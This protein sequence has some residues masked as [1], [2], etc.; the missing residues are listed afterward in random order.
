MRR[1]E[2]I[3]VVARDGELVGRLEHV[4]AD[5]DTGR[6]NGLVIDQG[7]NIVIV[8]LSAIRRATGRI[9][10]LTGMARDYVNLPLFNRSDYRLLDRELERQETREWMEQ[11]GIEDFEIGGES[12]S[13]E[14]FDEKTPDAIEQHTGAENPYRR[15]VQNGHHPRPVEDDATDQ[16]DTTSE[17]AQ[18]KISERTR[19]DMH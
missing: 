2:T 12:E 18:R 14:S 1:N 15:K 10:T 3:R 17:E 6:A 5:P 8:P 19:S 7:G 16:D 13:A 11:M 4:A 9:V